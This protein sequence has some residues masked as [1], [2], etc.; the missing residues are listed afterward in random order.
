MIVYPG[1]NAYDR[2]PDGLA[3]ILCQNL[4]PEQIPAELGADWVL[5]SSPGQEFFTKIE[6]VARGSFSSY[7]VFNG[8]IFA[9]FDEVL[10]RIDINGNSAAIPGDLITQT[11]NERV[12]FTSVRGFIVFSSD[13]KAYQYD[14]TAVTQINDPDLPFNDISS[15]AAMDGR[16][17]FT[18]EGTDQIWWSDIFAPSSVLGLAFASAETFEDNL[19][20]VVADHRELWLFGQTTIE[21]W[22]PTTD[23]AQPFARIGDLVLQKGTL[24]PYS[25][26]QADNTLFWVGQDA[27]VYRAE[28]AGFV[29]ISNHAIDADLHDLSQ[30]ELSEV[31]AFSYTDDG[32]IF[33]VLTIPGVRTYVY[34]ASTKGWHT[35][36]SENFKIWDVYSHSE[37][38][39][40]NYVFRNNV[41]SLL[42]RA[43]VTD[44]I[45]TIPGI[46]QVPIERI[47]TV[48]LPSTRPIPIA[49]LA[50]TASAVSP[51]EP[52]QDEVPASIAFSFSDDAGRHSNID[53]AVWSNEEVVTLH[54]HG[55]YNQRIQVFRQG[56]VRAPGRTYRF[57]T[58][59]PARWMIGPCFVNDAAH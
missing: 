24:S 49:R 51:T 21:V 27:I 14:G 46:V 10:Y 45:L 31:Y 39:S 17:L 59:D 53:Q 56:Q 26:V 7:G 47:A 36:K 22:R 8:D 58:T 34:D 28:G 38:F 55:Q 19:V 23:P 16:I 12:I 9:V 54:E 57:R 40:Q 32:H 20:R 15:V 3:P 42:S 35:R 50:L 2:T 6:G 48:N 13:G 37:A 11:D 43:A 33:Y 52:T 4:Y 30:D 1:A 18:Q 29:R 5:V 25:I 41:G 44:S